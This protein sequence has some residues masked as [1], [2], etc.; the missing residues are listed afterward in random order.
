[1]SVITLISDYGNIDHRVASI[2]GS[3]LSRD[4]DIKF[5]DI[6]HDISAY[7]L[8]QTAYIIRSCYKN[9][10]SGSIHMICVDSFFHSNRKNLIAKVDDHYFIM[11]DNGILNLIFFDIKPEYVYEITFNKNFDEDIKFT[12]T[13]IFVPVA[14]H[15]YNGGVP[16]V[17]GKVTTDIKESNFVNAAYKPAENMIVGQVMYIDNFGNA[18]SNIHK[19]FFKKHM[20]NAN[21]FDIRFRNMKLSKIHNQYTDL[22]VDWNKESANHGKSTAI[23]NDNNLLEIIVYKGSNR[24]GASTLLGMNVGENIYIE[25]YP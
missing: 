13:D 16:E 21:R 1:M 5:V 23:F 17:I 11:A 20:S 19:K 25:F 18:V 3:L 10:P 12:A 7:D 6:T 14:V 22:V 9:F 2:K 4:L 15:L 8:Q 24:N